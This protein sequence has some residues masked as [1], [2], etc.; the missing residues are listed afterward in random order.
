MTRYQV[1]DRAQ[2]ADRLLWLT[3]AW[4]NTAPEDSSMGPP[5]RFAEYQVRAIV[6]RWRAA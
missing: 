5:L 6:S 3:L 4:L 2:M 1:I